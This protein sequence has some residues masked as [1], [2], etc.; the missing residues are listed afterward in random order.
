MNVRERFLATMAFEPVDRIPLWEWDYWPETLRTWYLQGA[1]LDIEASNTV[2]R[3]DEEEEGGWD[4]HSVELF[5]N[6]PVRTGEDLP[7][8]LDANIRR[9]PLNSFIHPLFEYKILEEQGDVIIA[10]QSSTHSGCNC[11]LSDIRVKKSRNLIRHKKLHSL[12]FKVPDPQHL[13]IHFA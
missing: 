9:I 4:P 6:L 1:P 3:A 7:F 5:P 13:F 8:S 12:L 2:N 11:L 10:I